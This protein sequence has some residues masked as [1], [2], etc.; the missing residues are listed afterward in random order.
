MTRATLL[1]ADSTRSAGCSAATRCRSPS[2]WRP[3]RHQDRGRPVYLR[4]AHRRLP[5]ATDSAARDLLARCP[6]RRRPGRVSGSAMPPMPP[7]RYGTSVGAEGGGLRAD[8]GLEFVAAPP[9]T[10]YAVYAELS[11]LAPAVPDHQGRAGG[12]AGRPPGGARPSITA[13][14]GGN[15]I[16]F[17]PT[18]T[19]ELWEVKRHYDARFSNHFGARGGWL[20]VHGPRHDPAEGL[21]RLL[22]P[23]LRR[24]VRSLLRTY[25]CNSC[26]YGSRPRP[27]L[28]PVPP[29][30]SRCSWGRIRL[31]SRPERAAGDPPCRCPTDR[32]IP[33]RWHARKRRG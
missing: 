15:E 1:V 33:R 13:K 2:S 9:A 28:G 20:P 7:R 10:V 12:G 14:A 19:L 5:P 4:S 8:R 23:F 25:G 18:D 31:T 22:R 29:D 21:G 30:S 27:A 11:R 16:E 17:R 3:G 26:R 6:P 32:L 24:Y